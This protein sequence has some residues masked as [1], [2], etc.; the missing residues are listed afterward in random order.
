MKEF[1]RIVAEQLMLHPSMQPRDLCKLCYQAARGG[2]HLLTDLAAARAYLEA[3]LGSVAAEEIPLCEPISSEYVRVNLAAW[4]AEGRSSEE[5][6]EF[7]ARGGG[8]CGDVEFYLAVAERVWC[9]SGRSSKALSAFL[10][11]Y[12]WAGC[13][14]LHHSEEYRRAER[15]AYRVLR[16][17]LL[18]I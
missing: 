17:E 18:D 10:K 11:E 5:L 1:E 14:A 12:R 7:F 13:P 16:R 6:F 15:P 4:K 3:E 8:R 9:Q 2:D